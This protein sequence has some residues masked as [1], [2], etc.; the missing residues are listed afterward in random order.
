MALGNSL[1]SNGS[2]LLDSQLKMFVV[3]GCHRMANGIWR[4]G[5]GNVQEVI[6]CID[7]MFPCG[8]TNNVDSD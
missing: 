7:G 1:L 5:A 6:E 2:C 8:A 3:Q 4:A